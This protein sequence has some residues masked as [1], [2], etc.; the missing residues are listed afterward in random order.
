METQCFHA[1]IPAKN[2]LFGR[3]RRMAKYST[4]N[5]LTTPLKKSIIMKLY[6]LGKSINSMKI[7]RVRLLFLPNPE[8]FDWTPPTPYA[9]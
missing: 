3:V 2:K 4:V 9:P 5:R 6:P 7:P 1:S 8:L